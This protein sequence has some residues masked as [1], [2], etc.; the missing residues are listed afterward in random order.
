MEQGFRRTFLQVECLDWGLVK[1][2][3]GA[4]E[5]AFDYTLEVGEQGQRWG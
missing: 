5:T 1:V 2:V 3:Q 4:Q